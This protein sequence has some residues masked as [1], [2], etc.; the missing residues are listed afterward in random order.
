[1]HHL[2]FKN[3]IEWLLL[4]LLNQHVLFGISSIIFSS[5]CRIHWRVTT[6]WWAFSWTIICEYD[7]FSDDDQQLRRDLT[8]INHC[9][10]LE[11]NTRYYGVD[12]IRSDNFNLIIESEWS[13][14]DGH[15][16][17]KGSLVCIPALIAN[18]EWTIMYAILNDSRSISLYIE[19]ERENRD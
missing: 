13:W 16:Q 5:T 1:M 2:W 10:Y 18:M 3:T 8:M 17:S 19:S 7:L 9:Y 6:V 11:Y 14:C 4:L 15:A 12:D